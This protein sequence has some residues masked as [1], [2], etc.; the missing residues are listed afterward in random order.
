VNR[1]KV[2]GDHAPYGKAI[3]KLSAWARPTLPVKPKRDA[4]ATLNT[5]G[6]GCATFFADGVTR[7]L[8]RDIYLGIHPDSPAGF[9]A[10]WD[11]EV[12]IWISRVFARLFSGKST[13]STYFLAFVETVPYFATPFYLLLQ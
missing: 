12:S 11:R 10:D 1:K 3:L 13:G 5:A 8:S 6:G 7:N 4:S 2:R 9:L